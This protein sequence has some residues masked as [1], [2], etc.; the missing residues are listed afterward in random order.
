MK[1]LTQTEK[2]SLVSALGTFGSSTEKRFDSIG[3]VLGGE[4]LRKALF[5]IVL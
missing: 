5:S 4:A 1:D 3:P 2:N